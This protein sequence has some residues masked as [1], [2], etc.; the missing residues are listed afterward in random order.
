MSFTD[1]LAPLRAQPVTRLT[2]GLDDATLERLAAGHPQL[3][4]AV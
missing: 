4:A 1:R 3:V 2:A